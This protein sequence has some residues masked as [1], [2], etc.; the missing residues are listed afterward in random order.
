LQAQLQHLAAVSELPNVTIQI[1]PLSRNH[2]LAVDSFSILR[3]G[4]AT[5][6]MLHDVVSADHLRDELYVEGD[7]DT[8][9]FRLAFDQLAEESLS[10]ADSREFILATA[11]QAW[12]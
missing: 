3:F 2:G 10:P 1:L 9:L 4:Q 6:T 5:E 7:T 12:S 8:Y 11:V